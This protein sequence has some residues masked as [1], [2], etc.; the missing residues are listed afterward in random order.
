MSIDFKQEILKLIDNRR[1]YSIIYEKYLDYLL[2]LNLDFDIYNK[3]LLSAY[4]HDRL[5]KCAYCGKYC[6]KKF[7][8]SV[9]S[10]KS[11]TKEKQP[12]VYLTQEE[13]TRRALQ[14]KIDKYGYLYNN[15]EKANKTKL[16]K[17]GTLDFSDKIK[18][19]IKL[20]LYTLSLKACNDKE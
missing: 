6:V 11:R 19:T 12:K 20:I 14:G 15:S 9:C 17:Y 1:P 2:S 10:N 7:C 18:K 8:S 4:F 5:N 16:E 3:T 13:K